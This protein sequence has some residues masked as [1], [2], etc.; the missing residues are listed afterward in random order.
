MSVLALNTRP[1][2]EIDLQRL[3]KR[4]GGA[5]RAPRSRVAAQVERVLNAALAGEPQVVLNASAAELMAEPYKVGAVIVAALEQ[6]GAGVSRPGGGPG[7]LPRP[8]L[9]GGR[10]HPPV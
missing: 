1:R 7:G 6:A 2:A 9:G 4:S 8:R 10:L 3:T 5:S